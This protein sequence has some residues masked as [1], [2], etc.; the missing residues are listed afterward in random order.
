MAVQEREGDLFEASAQALAHGC[1]CA[2]AM[3]KGIAVE[4]RKRWPDMYDRYRELC[5]NRKFNPGNLFVWTTEDL[6]I[7]N[8]G[9]QRTWRTKA[10]PEAIALAVQRM[11]DHARKHDIGSIAMPKIGA[12]LGGLDWR[13]VRIILDRVIPDE[14]DV[15]VYSSPTS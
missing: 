14:V 11:V 15:T 3:G 13:E 7:Y 4:F 1:N 10:S 8:L 9:T 2:G 12:G 6:I 5:R